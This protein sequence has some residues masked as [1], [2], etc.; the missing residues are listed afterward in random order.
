MTDD[1]QDIPTDLLKDGYCILK[2]ASGTSMLP[3]I[4]EHTVLKIE[5][6]LS[7]RVRRGDIVY[8][9]A[10]DGS[11]KIHRVSRLFNKG[12]GCYLQA[13]GDN[14]QYPDTPVNL[15][16]VHGVV[17]AREENGG[18]RKFD[19]RMA[20]YLYLFFSRYGWYYTRML[21]KR[22]KSSVNLRSSVD[23]QDV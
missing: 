8:F 20:H 15:C 21:L 22:I 1:L 13:W 14:C 17:V 6:P 7:K 19:N 5:S 3:A 11:A 10:T 2:A 9:T 18:W 4:P 23:N 16:S 12:D